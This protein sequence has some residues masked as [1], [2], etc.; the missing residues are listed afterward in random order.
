MPVVF[1][2]TATSLAL[3]KF[4]YLAVTV[5]V[6]LAFTS[7]F[8]IAEMP[9]ILVKI[10]STIAVVIALFMSIKLLREALAILKDGRKWQV[11]ITDDKLSWFSPL[12]D[13]MEPFEAKLRDIA[14]VQQKLIRYK[15]SKRSP[16][17]T[18]H[19][20]FTDGRIQE[21]HPQLCGINPAKVFSALEAKGIEFV[22]S[23]ENRGSKLKIET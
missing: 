2:R 6:G 18:F 8:W 20:E 7:V 23:T 22:S 12:P 5:I 11:E 14:S 16:K 17:T 4:A 10:A 1:T 19:I 9:H 15:N 21:I 3:E 13:Q